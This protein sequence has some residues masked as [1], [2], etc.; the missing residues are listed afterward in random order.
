VVLF[1][2][3]E[4]G[5]GR[6]LAN[7]TLLLDML[8]FVGMETHL[9]KSDNSDSMGKQISFAMNADVVSTEALVPIPHVPL[10]SHTSRSLACMVVV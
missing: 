7:E 10:T 5:I 2:R 6:S 1:S 8:R 9:S 4:S 3:G